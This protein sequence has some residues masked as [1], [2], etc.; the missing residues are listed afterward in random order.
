MKNWL[1]Y[2]FLLILFSCRQEMVTTI[3]LNNGK[4]MVTR[5]DIDDIG[6]HMIVLYPGELKE[7]LPNNFVYSEYKHL[8]DGYEAILLSKDDS[9]FLFQ[10]SG[11]F[12]YHGI[13]SNLIFIR[14]VE[15]DSFLRI[16]NLCK[17][18]GYKLISNYG[19]IE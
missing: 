9:I 14:D 3:N 19:K 11:D 1:F 12:K 18:K 7:K 5:I 16:F 4:T 15:P 13:D 2:L 8:L 10:E 6:P 17:E